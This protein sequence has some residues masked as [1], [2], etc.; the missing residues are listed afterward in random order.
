MRFGNG[1][2][3]KNDPPYRVPEQENCPFNECRMNYGQKLPLPLEPEGPVFSS[4]DISKLI[5]F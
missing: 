4:S 5:Y 3:S 2:Y 1:M